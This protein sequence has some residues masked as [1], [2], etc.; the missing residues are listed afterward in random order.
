MGTK[1]QD[2]SSNFPGTLNVLLMHFLDQKLFYAHM[3]SRCCVPHHL[4]KYLIAEPESYSLKRCHL[5]EFWD[6]M[7]LK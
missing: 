2:R 3:F 4:F 5:K 1:N 6:E 7:N